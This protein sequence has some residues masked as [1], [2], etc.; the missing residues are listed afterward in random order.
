M[1]FSIITP[2]YNSFDKMSEFFNALEN[3]SFKDYEVIIIDDASSDKKEDDIRR[4]LQDLNVDF[5][6]KRN[7]ENKGPGYSRNLGIELAKGEYII[8]LDSDD[9]IRNDALTVLNKNSTEHPD[10]I[11]FGYVQVLRDGTE[12]SKSIYYGKNRHNEMGELKKL[13]NTSTCGKAYRLDIIKNNSIRFY[14]GYLAEDFYFTLNAIKHCKVIK[15]VNQCLYYYKMNDAS[16]TN[17]SMKKYLGDLGVILDE[18]YNNKIIDKDELRYFTLRELI[19]SSIVANSGKYDKELSMRLDSFSFRDIFEKGKFLQKHQLIILLLY[20][21]HLN[22][23]IQFGLAKY[24]K[25]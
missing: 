7:K 9:W 24:K 20:K 18:L 4:C 16:I 15:D 14:P 10:C 17:S 12:I 2:Y 11:T 22:K 8:F 6:Y 3:Q 19:Y 1:K 25:S 23:I 5:Q 21:L 13:I